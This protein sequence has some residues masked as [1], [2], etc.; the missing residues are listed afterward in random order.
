MRELDAW[1]AINIFAFKYRRLNRHD[2]FN[3]LVSPEAMEKGFGKF[4]PDEHQPNNSD[5]PPYSTDPAAAMEVL[6]K[7][8]E[9]VAVKIRR[10]VHTVDKR[11]CVYVDNT[12]IESFEYTLELAVASFAKKLFSK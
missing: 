11:W 7:C 12:D 3:V 4:Q 1:I 6:R 10:Q 8:A 5:A 9:K 2:A